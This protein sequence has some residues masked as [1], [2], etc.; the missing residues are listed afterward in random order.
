MIGIALRAGANGIKGTRYSLEHP[1]APGAI[2]YLPVVS[3]STMGGS[4]AD[5]VLTIFAFP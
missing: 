4:A 3:V 5:P 1:R 2:S